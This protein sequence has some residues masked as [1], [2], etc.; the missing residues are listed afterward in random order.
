VTAGEPDN[1]E[2]Y[3]K[4]LV[5]GISVYIYKNASSDPGGSKL[6]KPKTL[7]SLETWKSLD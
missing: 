5:E 7:V 4:Y 3:E 6:S 2:N 1:F